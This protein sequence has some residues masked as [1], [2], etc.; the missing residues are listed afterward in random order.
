VAWQEVGGTR[1][2]VAAR[3]EIGSDGTAGFLLGVYDHGYAL[4]IDPE[5][6]Y[7]TYLGGSSGDSGTGIAVDGQG[8]AYVS[9]MTESVNFP[10][11]G[12]VQGELLG[13]QD[14]FVSKIRADGTGLVYSTYLGGSGIEDIW[15]V[16]VDAQG[17]AYLSGYTYSTDFPVANAFQPNSRG[18]VD[19]FLAKLD[20]S[21]SSLAYSTYLGGAGRDESWGVA[22][23]AQGRAYVTGM[24]SSAD[25]PMANPY[26]SSMRGS[27]D[28]FVTR[29]VASGSALSYSTYAGG[30]SYEGALGIAIDA[31]GSAY[32]TG[33]TVS[34]DFPIANPYQ[35]T[36]HGGQD[37]F[38][39]KLSPSG[40][41]LAYS[42]YIGGSGDDTGWAIAVDAAGSAYA[43]GYTRSS[44]YPMVNAFQ[45]SPHGGT[46]GYV[47]KL[48][49]SGSSLAYSTYLGG[50]G[51]YDAGYGIGVDSWGDA[52]VTGLTQSTNFPTVNAEQSA[53]QG[54]DDAF[55][56]RVNS[57]GTQLVYST[58]LGGS[59][60]EYGYGLVVSASGDVYLTGQTNSTNFPVHNALQ[61]ANA[62]TLDAFVVKISG[63][64]HLH[65]SDVNPGDYFYEPMR[66]LYCQGAMSG[67]ADGTCRPY[68]N[69]TRG[70]LAKILVLAQAWAP[71]TSGGPHFVDVPTDN[72]F[73]TYVE[74]AY[75][76][77]AISGYEDGTFRWNRA[78]TRAQLSKIIVRAS[79]WPINTTGGP[80]FSDVPTDNPFYCYVET[81]YNH[82]IIS[83]YAD[84]TFRPGNNATRGQIATIVY[85]AQESQASAIKG[86]K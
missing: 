43:T 84:S 41:A 72:P 80:H 9:G 59:G 31:T 26:Q 61:A 20:P 30:S 2:P 38:V 13:S 71:D 27:T 33:N 54:G 77:S 74:T 10:N 39:T 46:E 60:N 15:A 25:F 45:A 68:S 24:T 76:H 4:T 70:Q 48:S 34:S 18:G 78:V 40:G 22:V 73:Y 7:S 86:Q 12:Q 16:A 62:G 85:N 42:T 21:G 64:C 1:R 3:F 8:N 53:H 37:V 49:A 58:Y 19:A 83:G 14:A 57:A 82:G 28:V 6:D 35:S 75:N 69:T 63:A 23:D 29:L 65:Y 66:S 67:Y 55:V 50:D 51:G 52:Y 79:G 32:V 56:T 47:S 17:S 11:A 36:L 5:F 44:N 81:A